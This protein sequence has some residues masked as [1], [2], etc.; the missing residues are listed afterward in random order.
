MGDSA[1]L[2]K[3]PRYVLFESRKYPGNFITWDLL[4]TIVKCEVSVIIYSICICLHLLSQLL[5][6]NSDGLPDIDIPDIHQLTHV[7]PKAQRYVWMIPMDDQNVPQFA[8]K[9]YGRSYFLA[10][11]KSGRALL[12]PGDHID[13]DSEVTIFSL[14]SL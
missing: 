3:P 7:D 5:Q 14:R 1:S 2:Q 13:V 9:T 6:K 11:A 12:V 10:F 4:G 8:L